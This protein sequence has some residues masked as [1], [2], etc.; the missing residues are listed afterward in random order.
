MVTGDALCVTWRQSLSWSYSIQ[1]HSI[2]VTPLTNPAEITDQGLCYCNSNA[3][4]RHNSHKSGVISI[5]DQLIFQN[6]K[7]LRSV[8]EVQL[9]AQNTALRHY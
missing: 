9:W 5:I 2:N 6:G 8:Q 7:K 1:F 4:Q 3:W